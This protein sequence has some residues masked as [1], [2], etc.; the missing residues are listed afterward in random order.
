[1]ALLSRDDLRELAQGESP[2]VS[3]YL[4]THRAG[5]ETQQDPIRFKNLLREAEERL[6]A[7]AGDG[8]GGELLAPAR[9]LL[10]DHPFWQHQSDGLAMFLSPG[11]RRLYRLPLAFEE[12]VVVGERFHLA[13]LLPLLG[14][15]GLFYVLALSQNRVRLLA[16]TR[17][18]VREIDLRDIPESLADALGYDWEQRSL[19]FH[20]AAP[21]GVAGPTSGG[22][23]PIYHGHGTG[24]DDEKEEVAKFLH[25]VDNGVRKLL[26]EPAEPVV[27]AAVDWVASLYRD[28]TKLN[29]L[30]AEPLEGNPD[31]EP[32]EELHRRALEKVEPLFEADRA[33][34]A[35]RF[36][37]AA[38]TGRAGERVEEVLLAAADGRVDVLWVDPAFHRWG[39]FDRAARKIEVHS[40]RG[41]G[42][43]DLL[44]RAAL[45]TLLHGGTVH[46]VAA[47]EVPGG[48][49]LAALYRF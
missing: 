46:A 9:R 17:H 21:R 23:A 15:D 2:C 22:R 24:V 4:P 31:V 47:E 12:L 37:V 36:A 10:D 13:P 20:S 42:D 41:N 30:V 29:N 11:V 28:L 48:E 16:A 3:L 35:E 34:A 27:V 14:G 44:D 33:R 38:G 45:E 25:L 49:G 5:A 1:M 6:S 19:Q 8:A 40:E 32:A 18:R 7:E 39:R 26:H 43:E